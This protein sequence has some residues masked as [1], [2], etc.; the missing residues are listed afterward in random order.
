[1]D[2][3]QGKLV[4]TPGA[5]GLP[6]QRD[7]G[8]MTPYQQA[9]D[10]RANDREDRADRREWDQRTSAAES[11]LRKAQSAINL[12]RTRSANPQSPTNQK[13]ATPE[14]IAQEWANANSA[15]EEV[16]ASHPDLLE[17][18]KGAGDYPYVQW[19]GGQK[20]TFSGGAFDR[21]NLICKSANNHAIRVPTA[22]NKTRTDKG[23]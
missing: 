13:G 1:M 15:V 2:A 19:K 7:P 23:R 14:E 20:L 9:S 18:G 22:G 8:E 17:G 5:E 11:S 10:A 16:T 21:E 3:Q 6:P 4:P 12:A